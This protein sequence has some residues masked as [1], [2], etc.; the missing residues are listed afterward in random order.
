MLGPPLIKAACS[1]NAGP[2]RASSLMTCLVRRVCVCVSGGVGDPP[3]PKV[4]R[5]GMCGALGHAV[6]CLVRGV[7]RLLAH[8]APWLLHVVS[9]EARPE[10]VD[11]V[12]VRV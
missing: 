2:R 7:S 8:L 5:A 9:C 4:G 11:A 6:T 10:V 3:C 1:P 12:T